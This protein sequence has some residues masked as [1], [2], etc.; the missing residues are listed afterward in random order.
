MF[1]VS[2]ILGIV[3]LA[4]LYSSF[5]LKYINGNFSGKSE[6]AVVLGAA[7]YRDNKP[8]PILKGRIE[9]AK[10]LIQNNEIGKVQLT[11]GKAPGEITEGMCAYNYLIEKGIDEDKLLLEEDTKTTSE[12]I[13]FI[14]NNL[15]NK[16]GFDKIIV[17]SDSFHLVRILE[18]SKFFNINVMCVASDYKLNWEKHFYYKIRDSIGLLL[19]W[20]F[21]I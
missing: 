12:Q 14:K 16:K 5:A 8:S 4:V 11:G 10:E 21:A 15:V 18:M 6:I 17:I 2:G 1:S 19:F 7:V 13:R 20:F 9:K 3:I